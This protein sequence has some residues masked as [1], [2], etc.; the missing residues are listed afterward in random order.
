MIPIPSSVRVHLAKLRR[1]NDD[2][3]VGG[4]GPN[5]LGQL[6][7]LGVERHAEGIVPESF[8][9]STPTPTKNE[10]IVA[11]GSR[12]NPSCT[13]KASEFIPRRISV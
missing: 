13:C 4:R 9:Q 3:T 5:E 11:W 6:Q 7:T 12:F 2:N 8:Y 10:Q 1:G